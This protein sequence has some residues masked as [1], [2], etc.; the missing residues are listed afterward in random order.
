MGFG[1][2][3]MGVVSMIVSG[4]PAKVGF[5]TNHIIVAGTDIVASTAHLLRASAPGGVETPWNI[6]AIALLYIGFR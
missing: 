3:E 4:I 1:I 6:L 2:G 5:G